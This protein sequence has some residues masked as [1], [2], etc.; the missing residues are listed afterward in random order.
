MKRKTVITVVL[1]LGLIIATGV[2]LVSAQGGDAV[3]HN[4][5]WAFQNLGSSTAQVHV[6][7]YDTSGSWVASDD[8]DVDKSAAFW[9]PTYTPL[10]TVGSFDGSIVASSSEPLAATVNQVAENGT[11]GKTGNAT[12][13]GFDD[14]MIAPTVYAPV[15]MK[16]YSGLFWTELSIQ[17]TATTGSTAVDVHYYDATGAEVAG[18]PVSYSVP[19]GSSKRV[20]QEDETILSAGFIGSVKVEATDG[21]TPIA[22]IVNEFDGRAGHMYDQFYAYEGFAAGSTRVVVPNVF[23]N[24]YGGSFNASASVQN[25]GSIPAQVTWHFYDTTPGNPNAGTEIHTIPGD[26]ITAGKSVYFPFEPYAQ[27]LMDGYNPGDNEWIGTLI[28]ESTNGQPLVAVVNQLNGTYHGASFRG[29]TEGGTEL[30][31]PMAYVDA[32]GFASTSYAIVDMTDTGGSVNVTVDYIADTTGCPTCSDC[33]L[34]YSFT[35]ND[36][37]YQPT[38]MAGCPAGTMSSDGKFIGSIKMTVNTAGKTING[39]MNELMAL[40]TSPGFASQDNFTSF[41]GSTP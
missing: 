21:T 4:T 5:S 12:Y 3:T 30:Y 6:D 37:Q 36:N 19:A 35:N 32:Y 13:G 24:G 28:L 27:I 41:N 39:V 16:G 34:T 2:A 25:L 31:F 8:F 14:N 33:S 26:T 15:V 29:L 9:A 17:S 20:A 11:S 38:H 23:I 10:N 40:T 18:S 22:L 1:T 7:L